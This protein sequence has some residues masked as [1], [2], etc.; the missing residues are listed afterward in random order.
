MIQPLL[1]EQISAAIDRHG[2]VLVATDFDGT[3]APIASRPETVRLPP[4]TAEVLESIAEVPECT[5]MVVS[6]R[7]LADL[8][9]RIAFSSVLAGNHG[10]EIEGRGLSFLHAEASALQRDLDEACSGLE[11]ALE[12]WKGAVVERKGLTATVHFRN[13]PERDQHAVA[14]AVRAFVTSYRVPFSLRAGKKA[15]EIHPRVAWHK[16]AAV[17][18]VREQLG[19]VEAACLC[20]GDDRTDETMFRS[21]APAITIA[22]GLGRTTSA[23]YTVRDPRDVCSVL[24]RVRD[25]VLQKGENGSVSRAVAGLVVGG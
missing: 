8:R 16:G 13:V 5:L 18:W 9:K 19:L 6:G 1:F 3:L 2:R 25:T 4:E 7:S 22:V 12:Q 23:E 15:L 24:T 17:N 21:C 20:I 10:L 11:A 14:L